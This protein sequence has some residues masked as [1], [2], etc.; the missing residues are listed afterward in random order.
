M[1]VC[2]YYHRACI[3][4]RYVSGCI[5]VYSYFRGGHRDF[6]SCR[7]AYLYMYCVNYAKTVVCVLRGPSERGSRYCTK[8]RGNPAALVYEFDAITRMHERS[9]DGDDSTTPKCYAHADKFGR[10]YR[11]R[12]YNSS[13]YV[14]SVQRRLSKSPSP[15]RLESDFNFWSQQLRIQ[16]SSG[17]L[18]KIIWPILQIVNNNMVGLQNW[19][20]FFMHLYISTKL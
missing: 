20:F 2:G 18:Y 13:W 7:N 1:R 5:Y 8:P 17:V 11:P 10:R 19:I 16:Y 14:S 12:R 3:F 15:S 4:I 6:V 9:T